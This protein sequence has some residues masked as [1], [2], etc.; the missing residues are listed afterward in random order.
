MIEP[1]KKRGSAELIKNFP[2]TKPD[3]IELTLEDITGGVE[4][5][6]SPKFLERVRKLTKGILQKSRWYPVVRL[7]GQFERR[8]PDAPDSEDFVQY[9]TES[10]KAKGWRGKSLIS[11]YYPTARNKETLLTGAHRLEALKRLHREGQI[12]DDFLVPVFAL[13]EN[14]DWL[15]PRLTKE[16]REIAESYPPSL[17]V[18]KGLSRESGLFRLVTGI[19]NW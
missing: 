14:W 2:T 4:T 18:V 13:S 19:D 10:I 12:P 16:E 5:D 11:V 8:T 7:L 3:K 6:I 1:V 15:V 17:M 9:L